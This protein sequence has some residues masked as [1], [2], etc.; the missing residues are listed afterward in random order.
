MF[1]QLL[2]WE[3]HFAPKFHAENKVINKKLIQKNLTYKNWVQRQPQ[4]QN[5]FIPVKNFHMR[6]F[7]KTPKNQNPFN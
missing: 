1:I 4:I 2:E 7:L 5:R 3:K 6:N